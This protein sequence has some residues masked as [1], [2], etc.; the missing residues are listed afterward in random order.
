M[1][2]TKRGYVNVLSDLLNHDF[3]VLWGGGGYSGEGAGWWDRCRR[4][5]YS[6]II[7]CQG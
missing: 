6:I 5:P 7:M 3:F 2:V 1:K 4:H